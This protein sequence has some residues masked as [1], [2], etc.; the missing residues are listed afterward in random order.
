[1]MAP[2]RGT[3]K[4]GEELM[5]GISMVMDTWHRPEIFTGLLPVLSNPLRKRGLL[6]PLDGRDLA[7]RGDVTCPRSHDCRVQF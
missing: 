6:C 2:L 1:M 3:L 4:S 7:G 5:V